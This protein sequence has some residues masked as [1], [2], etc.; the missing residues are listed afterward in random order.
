MIEPLAGVPGGHVRNFSKSV[1]D[2]DLVVV[3]NELH[4][5]TDIF[6]LKMTLSE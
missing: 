2:F 5:L 4:S 3:V 1:T 6:L